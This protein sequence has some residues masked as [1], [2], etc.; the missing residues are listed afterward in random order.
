[1]T[2]PKRGEWKPLTDAEIKQQLD[3]ADAMGCGVPRGFWQ[4]L[5]RDRDGWRALVK[6]LL[7]RETHK[8]CDGEKVDCVYCEARSRLKESE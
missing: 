3:Y 7:G 5:A 2:D 8:G 4:S 1:M 6:G